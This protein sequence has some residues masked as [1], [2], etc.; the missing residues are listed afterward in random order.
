MQANRYINDIQHDGEFAI[1]IAASMTS[2]SWKNG[3]LRWTEL[4]ARLADP[5]VTGETRAEFNRLSRED[6]LTLKDKAGG[7]VGGPVNGNRRT[8]TSVPF[9]QLLCL[10][11]DFAGDHFLTNLVA[12][13]DF[14]CAIHT[15]R[16]HSTDA[17]KYRV[18]VP[19]DRP[20]L[21]EEYQAVARR[22]AE[23]MGMAQFD[24]TCFQFERLMF[25]PTLSTDDRPGYQLEVI[26]EPWLC[27]DDVLATY[28]KFGGD[29][30]HVSLWPM[31][32][33]ETRAINLEVRKAGNPLEKKGIVGVFCRTWSIEEGLQEFLSDVYENVGEGRWTFLEGTSAAGVWQIP[34]E[35]YIKSFHGTDPVGVFGRPACLWDAVRIHKFGELEGELEGDED[36]SKLPSHKRMTEWAMSLEAIRTEMLKDEFDVIEDDAPEKPWT[37]RLT[38]LE[39]GNVE[40]TIDNV[41]LVMMAHEHLKGRIR[42]NFFTGDVDIV[43]DLP[44]GSTGT[45][46]DNDTNYVKAFLEKHPYRIKKRDVVDAALALASKEQGFHPVQD[47]INSLHWDG[48]PRVED[49]LVRYFG[50]EDTPYTRVVTRKFFVGGVARVMEPG[51]KWDNVLVLTGAQGSGKST[52]AYRISKGWYTD[53]LTSM[54]GKEGMEAV[55][56]KWVV[57]LG[58]LSAM[59]KADL[60]H[61]KAFVTSQFDKFRPAYGRRNVTFPRQC[62]FI[63]TTNETE[64]LKDLTGNRR[65]WPVAVRP[66]KATECMF[67]HLT[68]AVVDQ[69]WAE[70]H[71]LWA[72]GEELY[73]TPEEDASAK[74]VQERHVELPPMSALIERWLEEKVPPDWHSWNEE[75]RNLWQGENATV[76]LDR[77][78]AVEAWHHALGERDRPQRNE[79]AE[80]K[81]VLRRQKGWREGQGLLH[82]PWGRQRY[83][84]REEG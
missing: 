73:L 25:W 70:A 47:Y 39:N 66:R 79:L 18:L 11:A 69:M 63:G 22:L 32:D 3:T 80:V 43:G 19:L 83:L 77:V 13:T 68:P 35:E 36:P 84:E 59:K 9:R 1:A 74:V 58:E 40:P 33:A 57:E 20:V 60:E 37:S 52:F 55:Q 16:K 27:V 81:A 26:D 75:Q 51:I 41:K 24:H 15:T 72:L 48:V 4:I 14:A 42:D 76:R 8:R 62:V 23:Q 29:H 46:T 31:S 6:Q 64:F 2:K 5:L 34:G 21:F 30:T 10:D 61:A 65:W 56:G 53:S 44:W 38:I 45:W 78:S 49:C 54:Q 17:P 67:D 82:T 71:Q 12:T 7:Y 50:A 28:R